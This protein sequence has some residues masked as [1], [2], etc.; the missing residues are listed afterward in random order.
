MSGKEVRFFQ[1]A[2]LANKLLE[3]NAKGTLG[4]FT[5]DLVSRD[6]LIVDELGLLPPHRHAADL[7][8]HVIVTCYERRSVAINTNPEF[9]YCTTATN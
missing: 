4:S 7:L 1:T 5:R 3:R 8:F 2:D 6:L 9:R